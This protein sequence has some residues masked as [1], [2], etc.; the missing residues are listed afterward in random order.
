[1]SKTKLFLGFMVSLLIGLPIASAGTVHIYVADQK[2]EGCP[3]PVV[4]EETQY[5]LTPAQTIEEMARFFRGQY[6]TQRNYAAAF[7]NAGLRFCGP[8]EKERLFS[9]ALQ[10]LSAEKPNRNVYRVLLNY[11]ASDTLL[12]VVEERLSST[13]EDTAF[14]KNLK[15][16]KALVLAHRQTRPQHIDRKLVPE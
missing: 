3:P 1:M 7:T 10:F 11:Y 12:R 8:K 4:G 14:A 16:F 5:V 15:R 2:R 9:D 13:Q 6:D